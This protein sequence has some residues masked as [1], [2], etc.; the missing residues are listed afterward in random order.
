VVGTT[1][2]SNQNMIRKIGDLYTRFLT[3]SPTATNCITGFLVGTVGDVACQKYFEKA[4]CWSSRPSEDGK[5]QDNVKVD[6]KRAGELGLIRATLVTPF[7]QWW[8]A[9]LQH[10]APGNNQVFKRVAID[11][12]IGSPLVICMVFATKG[13]LLG[14]MQVSKE[15]ISNNLW[16]TW[17]AGL[18]YWPFVHCIN[19]RFVPLMYQPLVGTIASL[20]WNAVLSYYSNK[21]NMSVADKEIDTPV[22][23]SPSLTG[24]MKA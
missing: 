2:E 16:K 4:P 8:Y 22:E 17:I 14:D 20:Y 9:Y 21:D 18:S 19:F 10:L 5:L 24:A 11:S 7:C 12:A 1:Y 15:L 23:V 6:L 13:L 3:C